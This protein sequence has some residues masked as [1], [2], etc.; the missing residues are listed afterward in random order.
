M[1]RWSLCAVRIAGEAV[2]TVAPLNT[3]TGD[4]A[5]EVE[6]FIYWEADLLDE[7]RLDD[8]LALF[9]DDATYEVP[10]TDMPNG[11]PASNLFIIA[12]TLPVLRGRVERLK[13]VHAYAESPRARTRRFVSNVRLLSV[14]GDELIA[15]ANF[16]VARM[17][18]GETDTFI[19]RY[20]YTLRRQGD[21]SF[22][23]RRRRAILDLE[24]LRPAGK[25]SFIL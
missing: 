25:I 7:W 17:K 3:P 2:M 22:R 8:W 14:A 10:T 11:N 5:R 1:I 24:A 9:L 16:M 13:S 4:L 15:A 20:E 23:F 21:G 18:H 12:D 6:R 19:G